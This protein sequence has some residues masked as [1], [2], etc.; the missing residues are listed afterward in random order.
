MWYRGKRDKGGGEEGCR[1]EAV[2]E[3]MVGGWG[4]VRREERESRG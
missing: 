4:R 3:K 1:G 2:R